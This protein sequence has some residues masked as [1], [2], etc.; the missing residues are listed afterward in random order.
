MRTAVSRALCKGQ[1]EFSV[2]ER[3]PSEL[4][5]SPHRTDQD[6]SPA[7]LIWRANTVG[8]PFWS[9]GAAGNAGT[10]AEPPGLSGTYQ[11]GKGT[12]N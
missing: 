10:E 3:Q 4:R 9:L 12:R 2:L 7:P 6:P 1:S 5:T 8:P 11:A